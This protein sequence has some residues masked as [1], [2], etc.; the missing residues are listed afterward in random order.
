LSGILPAAAAAAQHLSL[1][2]MFANN[3]QQQIVTK[4]SSDGDGLSQ[5]SQ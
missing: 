5:D 1:R 2:F 4:T 3:S